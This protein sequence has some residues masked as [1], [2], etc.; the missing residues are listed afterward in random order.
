MDPVKDRDRIH[1]IDFKH[2]NIVVKQ[3]ENK[4]RPRFLIAICL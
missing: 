4:Y 3:I 1:I 2:M